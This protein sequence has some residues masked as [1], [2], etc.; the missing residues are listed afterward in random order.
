ME[1]FRPLREPPHSSSEVDELRTEVEDL[2]SRLRT[3]E[4]LVGVRHNG[5]PLMDGSNVSNGIGIEMKALEDVPRKQEDTDDAPDEAEEREDTDGEVTINESIWDAT[6]LFNYPVGGCKDWLLD[7]FVIFILCINVAVQGIFA[8]SIYLS[9]TASAYDEQTIDGYRSWRRSV[10][11]DQK[12]LDPLTLQS[13][14]SRVC[15][16]DSS[17]ELSNGQAAVYGSLQSYL[18]ESYTGP[19]VCTLC[20]FVWS[21]IVVSDLAETVILFQAVARLWGD[22]QSVVTTAEGTYR[23]ESICSF[24]M[25]VFSACMLAKDRG[26]TCMHARPRM[27]TH[28]CVH[29]CILTPACHTQHTCIHAHMCSTCIH[30]YTCVYAYINTCILAPG[31]SGP[32]A[33]GGGAQLSRQHHRHRGPAPEHS[34]AGGGCLAHAQ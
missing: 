25:V 31:S 34:R 16:G 27:E 4:Q 11:H 12:Y 22:H 32:C 7:A 33:A 15:E 14:V 9:L 30:K 3:V 28:A 21:M 10:G 29:T 20:C 6:L 13:L 26:T 8:I 23:I 19:I 5:N 2:R 18:D 17:L 24:R 1:E